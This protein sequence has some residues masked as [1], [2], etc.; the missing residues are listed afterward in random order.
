[1][2]L[3]GYLIEVRQVSY[4]TD[5]HVSASTSQWLS[6]DTNRIMDVWLT[7]A[8]HPI[9]VERAAKKVI[10]RKVLFPEMLEAWQHR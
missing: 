7:F 10:L 8:G 2:R 5:G 6:F 4:T 3:S 9:E 1:V